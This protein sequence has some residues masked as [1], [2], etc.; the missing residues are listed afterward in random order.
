MLLITNSNYD[1]PGVLGFI[2][3]TLGRFQV[4]ITNMHVSRAGEKDT[5][6]CLAT[7]DDPVPPEALQALREHE[8]IIETAIIEV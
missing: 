3:T 1:R 8:N 5:A 4:N 6:I 7:V 2:G